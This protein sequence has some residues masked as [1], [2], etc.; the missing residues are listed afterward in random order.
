MSIEADATARNALVDS[1][2]TAVGASPT[3]EIRSG[4]PPVGAAAADTGTLIVAIPL[5]ADWM[6]AAAGGVK[7]L[8]GS[9]AA[10][11]RADLGSNFIAAHW[12]LK[13]SGGVTRYQGAVMQAGGTALAGCTTTAGNTSVTAPANSIPRLALV[14]GTGIVP[15]TFVVSGGGTTTLVLSQPPTSGG[16]VTLTFTGTINLVNTNIAPNQPVSITSFD[17][18]APH[19]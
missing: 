9:W 6:A 7:A 18:T 19:A 5:P 12:R 2:E 17:L 8:L 11:A 10:N 4:G 15:G 16:S 1:V 3:L 13:T 14:S